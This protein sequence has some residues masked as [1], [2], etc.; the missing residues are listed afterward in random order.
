[1]SDI[2]LIRHILGSDNYFTHFN[3]QLFGVNESQ[4]GISTS[5]RSCSIPPSYLKC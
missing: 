5:M 3:T 1:M 4:H 2:C